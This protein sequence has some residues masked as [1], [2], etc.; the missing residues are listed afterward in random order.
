[1]RRRERRLVWLIS[2]PFLGAV[3]QFARALIKERQREGIAIAKAKK[4]YKGRKPAL[5]KV[6][7]SRSHKMAAE[8]LSRVEIV[9]THGISRASIYVYLNA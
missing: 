6:A 8:G 4:V 2:Y 7:I 3:G 1:M 5:D 9:E